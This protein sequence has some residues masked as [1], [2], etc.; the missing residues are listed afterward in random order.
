MEKGGDGGGEKT[1][2]DS[3]DF[4]DDLWKTVWE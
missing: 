4:S 3:V 2:F 1:V